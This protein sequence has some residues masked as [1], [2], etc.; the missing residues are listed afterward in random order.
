LRIER[1]ATGRG[2]RLEA[3]QYVPYP[4]NKV[5]EFFSDALNL[6]ALTPTWLQFSIITP[7][8][9]GIAAGTLIDY[10]VRVHGVPLRWQSRISV[11]EPPMR[12]VD[13]QLRGPY[14][15]WRHEHVF[16]PAEGGVVCRDAVEY[17]VYGGPLVNALVVRPE[18]FKIFAFRQ[19]KLREFF[20]ERHS[21][22]RIT[23][24]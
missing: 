14:R 13:E 6:Q 19:A 18:L 5:F 11:W 2:F 23:D 12:F 9:I 15:S 16:E 4:Q 3:A 7:T 20:P 10:R 17:E 8:P 21:R 24:R 1:S 22:R